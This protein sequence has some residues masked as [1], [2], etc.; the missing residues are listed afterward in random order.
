MQIQCANNIL[1]PPN[2][3]LSKSNLLGPHWE[4]G[5]VVLIT[6]RVGEEGKER[7]LLSWKSTLQSHIGCLYS[8]KKGLQQLD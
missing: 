7:N 6:D 8:L 1:I 5:K 2:H 3:L 4:C